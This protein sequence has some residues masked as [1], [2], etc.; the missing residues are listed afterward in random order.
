MDQLG[1][2]DTALV[3]GR[4]PILT[5]KG[6]PKASTPFRIVKTRVALVSVRLPIVAHSISAP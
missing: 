2:I 5:S 1:G 3:R 4:D 6:L